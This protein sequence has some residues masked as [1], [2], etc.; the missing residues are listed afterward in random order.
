ME[1]VLSFQDV[2]FLQGN[3]GTEPFPDPSG[4]GGGS[5]PCLSSNNSTEDEA[6]KVNLLTG[7]HKRSAFVLA[8]EIMALARDYGIA[9]L[10]FLT[11]TFKENLLDMKE[12]NRRFNSL[13]TG[14][15]K[16]R[17]RRAV[18]VPERQQR[19]AIHFHLLAVLNADIRTGA[20][21]D[22]IE[23]GDYKSANRALKAEWSF[24]RRTAPLYGFGRH[25][26][27][28]VKS[29]SEGIAR[30]V[31]KY[32]SKHVRERIET[33]KG[34]RLV[35]YLGY[36]R[37]GRKASCRLA[38]NTDNAWLWRHKLAAF[39]GRQGARDTDDLVTL[40]GPRWAY[41]LYESIMAERLDDVCPSKEIALRSSGLT[42]ARENVL[43]RARD[44]VSGKKFDKTV[45][46]DR[47]K[48]WTK[49]QQ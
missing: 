44:S 36:G 35:R 32:I 40:F 18:V 33:D 22:A 19:G 5:L 45:I 26:L 7:G 21:F 1:S 49:K 13:N 9:N 34:A 39:A 24:W 30:Y 17:Y 47:T 27:L 6:P 2:E 23:R 11:L 4:D 38:W 25:E 12:A 8:F 41:R 15:L 10:G 3:G 14:V 20:D 46:L 37:T 29:N 31:G 43:Q 16:G 42:Q 48:V 28:P